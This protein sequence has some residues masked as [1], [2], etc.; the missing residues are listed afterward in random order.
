MSEL[1]ILR[2]SVSEAVAIKKDHH[3]GRGAV[4]LKRRMFF[5]MVHGVV[6]DEPYTILKIT[7]ESTTQEV[8]L[9]AL[10]KASLGAERVHDYILVE[11][12][13]RSWE[14]KDRDVP[15]G[16]ATASTGT[17]ARLFYLSV[18]LILMQLI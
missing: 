9:Q 4:P 5:L 2:D 17:M 12:V 1:W 16:E 13:A 8:V 14:K 3:C 10:Q 6:P 18:L 7:Q 15:A 11:E